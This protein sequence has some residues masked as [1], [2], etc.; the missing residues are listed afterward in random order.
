MISFITASLKVLFII[1]F[2]IFLIILGIAI[3]WL[4]ICG[5][6]K[7]IIKCEDWFDKH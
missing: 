7:L 2:L 5:A 6:T 1:I 3:V 4:M